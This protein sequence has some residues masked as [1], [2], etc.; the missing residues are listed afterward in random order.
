MMNAGVFQYLG[1]NGLLDWSVGRLVGWFSKR[2]Q[3]RLALYHGVRAIHM[4]FSGQAE[5]TFT[6]ALQILL[7]SHRTV[8]RGVGGRE[9]RMDAKS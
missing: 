9:E 5:E 7:V 6:E 8:T 4:P 1:F 3:Q 2:V